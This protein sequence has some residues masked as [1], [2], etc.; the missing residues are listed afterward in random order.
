MKLESLSHSDLADVYIQYVLKLNDA[1]EE[2]NYSK[3]FQLRKENTLN[4]FTPFL[5]RITETVRTEIA[6]SA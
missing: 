1:I 5:D 2:G 3:V 4:Y 6:K